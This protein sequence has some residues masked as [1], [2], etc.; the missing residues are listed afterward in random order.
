MDF[1]IAFFWY[2]LAFFAGSLLAAFVASRV[3][4]ARSEEEAFADTPE[5]YPS[6]VEV[7]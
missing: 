1:V 4:P 7:P 6:D 5:A 3:V 2:F